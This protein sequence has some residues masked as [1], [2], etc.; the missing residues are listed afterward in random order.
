MIHLNLEQCK[1]LKEL[2][3]SQETRFSYYDQVDPEGIL[4]IPCVGLMTKLEFDLYPGDA[5]C[6][7]ICAC[8]ALEEILD[9]LDIWKLEIL[10]E[11][12]DQEHVTINAWNDHK[13]YMEKGRSSLEAVYMLCL[14]IKNKQ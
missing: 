1:K 2:G 4:P 8:P 7:V 10:R 9:W 5:E 3:F 13:H 6:E 12:P 14:V 11:Y